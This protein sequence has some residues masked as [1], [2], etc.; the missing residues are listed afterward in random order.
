MIILFILL[1]ILFFCSNILTIWILKKSLNRIRLYESFINELN[2]QVDDSLNVLRRCE[3][4]IKSAM[5]TPV[6]FDDPIVHQII[7]LIKKAHLSVN[8]I[9]FKLSSFFSDEKEDDK[10]EKL[11]KDDIQY[12]VN[13]LEGGAKNDEREE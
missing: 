2:E 3:T 7:G 12:V 6:Q 5:S 10:F 8:R 13:F 1:T 11:E 4:E 9:N